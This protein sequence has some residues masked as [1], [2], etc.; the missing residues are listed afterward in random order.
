MNNIKYHVT[1]REDAERGCGVYIENVA[2][3]WLWDANVAE[4]I[5]EDYRAYPSDARR[6]LMQHARQLMAAADE[7]LSTGENVRQAANALA[8]AKAA[9]NAAQ[10]VVLLGERQ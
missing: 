6:A 7:I 4:S 10:I 8:E 5:A 9:V 1:V 2:V 3:R